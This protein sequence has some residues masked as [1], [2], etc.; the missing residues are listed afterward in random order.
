VSIPGQPAKMLKVDQKSKGELSL[1][2]FKLP[3]GKATTVTVSNQDTDGYV[4]L[5]GVQF[6]PVK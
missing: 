4:I 3:A 5:D 2:K 1:G 6:K